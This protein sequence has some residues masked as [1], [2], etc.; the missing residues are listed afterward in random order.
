MSQH[1]SVNGT[2]TGIALAAAAH[3]ARYDG[4]TQRRLRN[5]R[6]DAEE[7]L[8][9]IH[10]MQSHGEAVRRQLPTV[11]DAQVGI[12]IAS[13][14]P[15]SASVVPST[16]PM[17]RPDLSA[18][19]ESTVAE[20]TWPPE[21][22]QYDERGLVK[23]AGELTSMF[24]SLTFEEV[25]AFVLGLTQARPPSREAKVQI[26]AAANALVAQLATQRLSLAQY[27]TAWARLFAGET[28]AA[29]ADAHRDP[30]RPPMPVGALA[31]NVSAVTPLSSAAI[32]GFPFANRNTD[33]AMRFR[34]TTGAALVPPGQAVATIQFGS[35][36]RTRPVDG[37]AE[38][39]PTQPVVVVNSAL[40]RFYADNIIASSF[41]L[42]N[43]T[44]LQAGSTFDVF[45]AVAG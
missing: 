38:P 37:D 24:L 3:W 1:G 20:L 32:P 2:I 5:V 43:S 15:T 16:A 29:A 10:D 44:S 34:V 36:Y 33:A 23:Q 35:E 30:Q 25:R 31:A 6:Q 14:Q 22:G 19:L 40:G 42:V 13:P 17:S 39:V 28:A 12:A 4:E 8:D 27:R 11:L 21:P 9:R 7:A 18:Q 41:T 26:F 45:I